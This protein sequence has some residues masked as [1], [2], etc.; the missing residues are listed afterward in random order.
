MRGDQGDD[1]YYVDNWY[2]EVEEYLEEGTDTV[3]SSVSYFINSNIENLTLIGND[4]IN[5]YGN[6]ES[7]ILTGNSG[8]NHLLDNLDGY[9][10]LYGMDGD[11]LLQ[12]GAGDDRLTV[13]TA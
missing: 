9:D 4:N 11:N 12:S 6:E 3:Y 10:T 7:N 5:G 13:A 8:N 2:N 1:I